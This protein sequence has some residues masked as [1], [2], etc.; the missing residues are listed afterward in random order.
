MRKGML[1]LMCTGWLWAQGSVD[2]RL[3]DGVN[4]MQRSIEQAKRTELDMRDPYH[5][6]KA[7]AYRDVSYAYASNME[8][9]SS[10]VFMVKSFSALSKLKAG[11]VK[12]DHVS[13]LEL[14]PK[15]TKKVEYTE[16]GEPIVYEEEDKSY[17]R[18]VKRAKELSLDLDTLKAEITHLRENKALSCAPV[19][20]ARAE[21]YYEALSYELT[22]PEGRTD[23]I[24]DFYG[25]TA[26]A[27]SKG[28]EKVKI[29]KE[30]SLECYTGK[31]FVVELPKEEPVA[32]REEVPT[33]ETQQVEEEP[34][35]V[36]ARIHFD[37]D[38]ATIKREYLPLL[39]EVVKVLKENPNVRVRIEGFTDSIGPKA[40]NEKL[41][42]RRAKAVRDYLVKAGIP[43]DRIDIAG[44]G[45]ER[46]ITDNKTPIGR[47]TNR[48]A[49]FIVI[50]VPGQ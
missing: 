40:Y 23:L 21:A 32:R 37:F 38:R 24:M 46:Y 49:E 17:E 22:R 15:K 7:R 20:L 36:G 10:K 47:L 34:L 27:L 41:A 30:G 50:K 44:F 35:T 12:A 43:A 31:P 11:Q 3:M 5:F 26:A 18:A 39:N 33:Q 8:E 28:L 16:Y 48:R 29:A 9:V 1:L 13:F 42:L 2:I 6:E 4:Q 14:K 19:E 45:K 25:K